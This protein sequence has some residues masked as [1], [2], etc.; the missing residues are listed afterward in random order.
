MSLLSVA[1]SELTRRGLVSADPAPTPLPRGNR[2]RRPDPPRENW[3]A[4]R[5][6]GTQ[7]RLILGPGM[8]AAAR[9]QREFAANCPE[10]VAPP[11]FAEALSATEA[12]GEP[13]L[14]GQA[15]TTAWRD[16]R[17]SP[18]TGRKALARARQLLAAT[19][20][21]ST[22]AARAAE[23]KDWT[24]ELLALPHW[25]PDQRRSLD[26]ELLPGLYRRL[27]AAPAETRW[28]NGDFSASN[29]LVDDGGEPR[30]VDLEFARRTHFFGEDAVRFNVLA[31]AALGDDAPQ[32]D[33][34]EDADLAWHLYFWLRQV[35]LEFV[36]NT[37]AYR[38]RMLPERLALLG[39]LAAHLLGRA[40]PA[41][42]VATLGLEHQLEQAHWLPQ[43]A[44]T[45]LLGGW[46]RVTGPAGL[47]AFVAVG[48]GRRLARTA[49][50]ARPDV[51]RHFPDDP[52]AASTGFALHVPLR[53]L[54]DEVTVCALLENGALLPAVAVAAGEL[55]R[56]VA[57]FEDYAAWAA[58]HDPDPPA[59][60]GAPSGAGPR[61]SILL[62]VHGPPREVLQ[63]CLESVR[64]QHHPRWEL[65]IVDD[66]SPSPPTL[67]LLRQAAES[68]SRIHLHARR[69]NGGISRA[70]ND[71]LAAAT[72]D[73][74]VLLDHDDV[75]RP[76]ALAEFAAVLRRDP[77]VDVL[78]SDEDKLGEGGRRVVPL[79]KPDYSPELALGVMY[80]G[81]ALC[82]RTSLAR[83][84]GGF[85]PEFDG[86]QDYEFFLRLT[87]R[88]R[89]I[90]HV[91]RMLYHWRQ[92]AGS[93]ALHGNVKGDMDARQ[94]RAVTAHLRRRGDRRRV[95]ALTGHRLRVVAEAADAPTVACVLGWDPS[96]P[97]PEG[98][99]AELARLGVP[100]R[101]RAGIA[102]PASL[103]A[104]PVEGP[105]HRGLL[106]AAAATTDAAILMLIGQP[107]LAAGGDWLP[108]LAA[109]AALAD[110]G[111]VAPL[112]V[113]AGNRVLES[114]W[115]V[116][117]AGA[118][119]V[120][121]GY[122]PDGD[123]NHGSLVC[124]REV[125]AVSPA[126][127]ALRREHLDGPAEVDEDWLGFVVRLRTRGCHARVCP[128]AR[129]TLP[130]SWRDAPP[131]W[132]R[133]TAAA[134][135]FFNPHFDPVRADYRLAT[136][137]P[138]FTVA[139]SPLRWHLDVPPKPFLPDG[140]LRV[141]GWAFHEDGKPVVIRARVAGF[142]WS[143]A[144]T[145]A[146]PDVAAGH[147][148]ATAETSGFRFNLRVPPGRHFLEMVAEADDGAERLWAAPLAVSPL[149]LWRRARVRGPA[150]TAS[151]QLLASPGH[152][153]RPVRP[154]RFPRASGRPD[155]PRLAI[156]TPSYNQ[157]RFLA[158]TMR[159]VLEQP[160][161]ACH[162]VVQ[163]GASADGSREIIAQAAARLHAW[164]SAPDRGQADAIVRGFAKTRGRPD[165]LMAWINSDDFYLPGALRFVAEYFARHPEVDAVYGH[166]ILVDEESRE[167][168]RWYLPRHRDE[169]LRLVDFV[170][171]ET[172]FWRR[173]L[174]DRVGG[175]DPSLQ[176]AMD[177]DL[178]LRFAAAGARI[179]RLPYF[180]GCF[181][182]HAAQ[183]TT[184]AMHRVGQR[185]IDRLRARTHGR[186]LG[187]AEV[188]GDPR[189]VDYLRRSAWTEWL[190]GLGIRSL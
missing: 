64:R 14:P 48:D 108:Q 125:A 185:E 106:A 10:L 21:P 142:A 164:E 152:A 118:R 146:R 43:H 184:S 91:P 171:Q 38:E 90:A 8:V 9:T 70:T 135:P 163:D 103:A 94:A 40:Q 92:S 27:S 158:A 34:A 81:H 114:G 167:V 12:L 45:V 147:G 4:H 150:S 77:A 84:A 99:W 83:A 85:D 71:A 62:P 59:P 19:A 175:L 148:R 126:C 20:R 55:R 113:D 145:E 42:P 166:R 132:C 180:L 31:S 5:P 137:P 41:W 162:Y 86:V 61:F 52:R 69:E 37:A 174:W 13:F 116:G 50:T 88:T 122:D 190:A 29:L 1:L 78:Y 149:A 159:S 89:R 7:V 133:A 75:L 155:L 144:A 182:L 66:A 186:E 120:M 76:H 110:S 138:H 127:V 65:R 49:P 54:E 157:A 97:V 2:D 105:S 47:R 28:T 96:T 46:C 15:L 154:E 18:E 32:L 111:P 57:Q 68:D 176:F 183:K 22:E 36:H 24:G 143:V 72:G 100:I 16:R 177:W 93:S 119:P 130:G 26:A 82:V 131:E 109:C 129:V 30:L 140:A 181:R 121:R 51:Q 115:T 11:A 25:T 104:R 17:L 169:V 107:F 117:P 58:R 160:G 123:G 156:V 153:P 124:T 23:W 98:C 165:D 172:L 95:A 53:R 79:L 139:R 134:D 67:D 102:V 136:P 60:A 74:V 3:I 39:R 178:L 179:V 101:H 87:E 151:Y 35:G 80:V 170:P 33:A 6:D 161:V 44:M 189:L 112:I 173:R 187:A 128:A 63:E 168:G 73:Y 56:G 188:E 141:L